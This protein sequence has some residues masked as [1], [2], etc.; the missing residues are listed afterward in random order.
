MTVERGEP[1]AVVDA[2]IVAVAADVVL[3][4]RHCSRQRRSDWRS[5][6]DS[7]IHAGVSLR[8][9]GDRVD[10]VAEFRG[11]AAFPARSNGGA[12]AVRANEGNVR[13]EYPAIRSGGDAVADEIIDAVGIAFLLLCD[14]LSQ[15]AFDVPIDLCHIRDGNRHGVALLRV[16]TIL[17]G[18]GAGA[19]LI[20]D[21]AVHELSVCTAAG[22]ILAEVQG[23]KN[24]LDAD[25]VKALSILRHLIDGADQLIQQLKAVAHF[26]DVGHIFRRGTGGDL[27][28]VEAE[29][30]G[31]VVVIHAAGE[32]RAE[33]SEGQDQW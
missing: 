1:V 20:G 33:K 26:F 10:A 11:D 32:Q 2:Y 8:L 23:I 31:G 13:A 7:Q 21:K 19:L 29:Q 27:P 24:S 12:E 28:T 6:G 15:G 22:R 16:R 18:H 14:L 17:T 4:D 25:L 3:G 30:H 5:R 9:V